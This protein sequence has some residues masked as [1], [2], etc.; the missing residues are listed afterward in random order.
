MAV[1]S[2]IDGEAISEGLERLANEVNAEQQ[3]QNPPA[4]DSSMIGDMVAEVGSEMLAGAIDL[5][6]EAV[7]SALSVT[8]DLIGGI[9]D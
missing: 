5:A 1:N 2:Q 8:G 4:S 6:G 3:H 7:G 9:F